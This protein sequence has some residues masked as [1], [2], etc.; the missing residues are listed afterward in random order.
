LA[1]A[2]ACRQITVN[3]GRLVCGGGKVEAWS[4]CFSSVLDFVT[5]AASTF[6]FSAECECEAQASSFPPRKLSSFPALQVGFAKAVYNIIWTG[7][8]YFSQW[9]VFD[10]VGNGGR[11]ARFGLELAMQLEITRIE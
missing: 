4:S 11:I 7:S 10:L 5:F 3:A 6:S 9:P 2:L 1:A 8:G